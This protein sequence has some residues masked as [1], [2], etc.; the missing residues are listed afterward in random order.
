M[1]EL[2]HL[3]RLSRLFFPRVI[4]RRRVRRRKNTAVITKR[5]QT[6]KEEARAL[7][8]ARLTAFN[9]HYGFTYHR[10]TIRAQRSRWGSC[11]KKGTLNFNYAILF[12]PPDLCD[13][14]IVHELCHLK[15]FNHGKAFWSLVAETIPD[16][17]ERKKKLANIHPDKM[18]PL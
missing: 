1:P 15:E 9:A 18:V 13:A 11:S 5:Y 6:Y 16:Y 8:H 2:T 17:L 7:V 12:L 14:V 10:V 4:V 3:K